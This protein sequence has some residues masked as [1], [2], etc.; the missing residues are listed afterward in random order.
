M[1]AWIVDVILWDSNCTL[2]KH[3]N[4]PVPQ[5]SWHKHR[6]WCYLQLILSTALMHEWAKFQFSILSNFCGAVNLPHNWLFYPL[7]LSGRFAANLTDWSLDLVQQQANLLPWFRH[8]NPIAIYC[9]ADSANLCTVSRSTFWWCT[10]YAPAGTIQIQRP[11]Y[12]DIMNLVYLMN[13]LSTEF[14]T[15]VW[16]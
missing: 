2:C 14:V 10:T 7:S 6:S 15:K 9:N 1:S 12:P 4:C 16:W 13:V 3:V 11:F 8:L 5:Q